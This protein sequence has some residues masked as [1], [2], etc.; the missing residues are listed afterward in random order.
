MSSTRTLTLRPRGQHVV[1]AAEADVV[2]PAVA[3]DDPDA[4]PHQE[5]A[6]LQQ[7]AARRRRRAPRAAALQLG[8]ALALRARCSASRRLRSRSRIASTRSSPTASRS[9]REQLAGVARPACRAASRMP[10]PNSALSS[11][12]ELDQ[13]GPRPS[14]VRQSR[15]WSAGCRRR[16][17]SSRWRWRSAAR[18]PKSCVSSLRYG[19]SPQP[20][21]AP[22]NSNSGCR[23]CDVLAPCRS[24]RCARSISGRSQEEV[25]VR[26]LRLAQRRA[27]APC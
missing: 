25:P 22:E 11:N 1:E 5:S 6:T 18:S 26:A 17:T 15:A 9:S 21:Q 7:V 19:V 14:R 12:S 8:D 16:S 24:R 27:A 4:L 3:A 13:A 2:G 20:A 10:R 23:S